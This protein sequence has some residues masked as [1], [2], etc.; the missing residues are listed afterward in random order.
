MTHWSRDIQGDANNTTPSAVAQGT[1]GIRENPTQD[2]SALSRDT[3]NSLNGLGRI[4]DKQKIEEQQ[5]LAKV[6]GEEAFRLAHNL[7]DDG[8]GRKVSVHA[9]IGGIMS[10]ITGAAFA[11]G[12]IGAGALGEID[13][14]GS[15]ALNATIGYTFYAGNILR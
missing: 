13:A 4:F 2:I 12:A 10:Q 8:S 15:V 5:D 11:S 1:I 9:I 14:G 6:F 3:A 7:P